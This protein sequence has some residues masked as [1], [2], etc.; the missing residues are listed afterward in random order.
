M[1]ASVAGL[2]TKRSA[3]RV[4]AT[5]VPSVSTMVRVHSAGEAGA[6]P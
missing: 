1:N 6:G 2:P 5:T 4:R 3:S